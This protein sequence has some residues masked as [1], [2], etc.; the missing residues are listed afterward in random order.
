MDYTRDEFKLFL[1]DTYD[2]HHHL[3]DEDEMCSIL[4][5]ISKQFSYCLVM[6]NLIPPITTVNLAEQYYQRIVSNHLCSFE[7][8]MT[9]YLTRETTINDIIDIQKSEHVKAVK[10]Y[11]ANVT[12]NSSYGVNL[13][14]IFYYY[15]IFDQMA[16]SE[17]PLLIHGECCEIEQHLR[18]NVFLETIFKN[19]VN[20]FPNLRIVMEH[21]STKEAVDFITKCGSNVAATITPHHLLSNK[22]DLINNSDHY[23]L[24]IFKE[25]SDRLALLD[26]AT[27]GNPKFFCG[28][29]SAPH[30]QSKKKNT[31]NKIAGDFTVNNAIEL[32]AEAFDSIDKINLLPDFVCTFGRNFYNLSLPKKSIERILIKKKNKIKDFYLYGQNDIVVPYRAGYELNWT[33]K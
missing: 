4:P 6:P 11:P 10:L 27:S 8:L 7:P 24:P 5:L 20:N 13:S 2:F 16:K 19:L 14:E 28:T 33:L 31:K 18:E 29:D 22:S 21:I 12:T 32:Y 9:I 25:E 17:I 26:A 1:S 15:P 23:C 30:G 3:R